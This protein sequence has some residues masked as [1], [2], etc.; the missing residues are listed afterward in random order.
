MTPKL[1]ILEGPDGAGKTTLARALA[2]HYGAKLV[3]HDAQPERKEMFPYFIRSLRDAAATRKPV[4]FDRCWLSEP[5]YGRVLR[6]GA[7]R[8]GLHRRAL[9]RVALGL[10]ALLVICL[11]PLDTVLTNFRA[12]RDQQLPQRDEQV[13]QLHKLYSEQPWQEAYAFRTTA[14]DYTLGGNVMDRLIE[15]IGHGAHAR[16]EGPG[17]GRWAPREV[18]L[19]IGETPGERDAHDTRRFNWPFASD[20]GCSPWL[21]AQLERVGISERELYWVN[22]IRADGKWQGARFVEQLQP[23]RIVALG[24]KARTWCLT[25]G[26]P[27]RHISHP[28]FWKRFYAR[29]EWFE[30]YYAF[31][32]AV[33]Y[34]TARQR[35]TAGGAR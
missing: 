15:W 9:N 35:R 8:V 3:R 11:P 22:A 16:N 13:T 12:T 24:E 10:N 20:Q 31:D 28:Q 1:I 32:K 19:M 29:R 25:Q 26:L 27:H 7:D 18:T 17:I 5:I 14:Y 21:S 33:Q 2:E 4:I 23:A 30:L 34:E 6:D